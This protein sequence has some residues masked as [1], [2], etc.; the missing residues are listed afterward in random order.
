MATD[1]ANIVGVRRGMCEQWM[2]NWQKL[3]YFTVFGPGC[4]TVQ[5]IAQAPVGQF[6]LNFRWL[7]GY[8]MAT[9]NANIVGVRRGMWELRLK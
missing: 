2:K 9:N 1:N 8:G 5:Q 6:G 7:M 4:Q 3:T